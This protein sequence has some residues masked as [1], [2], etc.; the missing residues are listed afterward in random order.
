MM[1][2]YAASPVVVPQCSP[3]CPSTSFL[4]FTRT[5]TP[6]YRLIIVIHESFHRAHN[7]T[8]RNCVESVRKTLGRNVKRDV[9]CQVRPTI[10]RP[11]RVLFARHDVRARIQP[12]DESSAYPSRP[13]DGLRIVPAAQR[14]R[15]PWRHRELNPRPHIRAASTPSRR[16]SAPRATR[17]LGSLSSCSSPILT[18]LATDGALTS[19]KCFF[20]LSPVLLL[21]F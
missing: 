15:D 20:S 11:Q 14:R 3:G 9:N 2:A 18:P 10:T 1:V 19:A 8:F 12:I 16:R 5:V 13:R 21:L 4:S 17:D 7:T 6:I